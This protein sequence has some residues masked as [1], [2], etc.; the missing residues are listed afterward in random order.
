MRN[1]LPI[2]LFALLAASVSLLACSEGTPVAPTGT[3]LTI[4]ASPSS[5]PLNG[6]SEITVIGRR[7]DGNPLFEGT[8]I[9]F[10]TSLGSILGIVETDDNGVA[11]AVLTADNRAGTATITAT[12]GSGDTS[13]ETTVLVGE[14]SETQLQLTLTADPSEIDFGETSR[15]S[16]IVRRAD[17]SPAAAGQVVRFFA[18]LGSI[19]SQASTDRDGIATATLTSGD[20]AGSATVTAFAGS[21]PA[22][23]TTV[24]ISRGGAGR[25]TLQTVNGETTVPRSGADVRLRATVRDEDG[26]LLQGADVTFEGTTG[27]SFNPDLG[28]TN[29]SGQVESTWTIGAQG[30]AVTSV[31]ARAVVAG[32]GGDVL[33]AR[34]TLTVTDG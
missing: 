28:S 13:A 1:L 8:E 4:S 12:T 29:A 33:I 26:A 32:A 2:G 30:G 3:V 11:R 9:R 14:S 31:E 10:S 15:I 6:A 24:T 25:I 34:V 16:A 22:A 23:T 18:S 5:I 27:T 21:S 20:E 17:G 7:P 19:Q